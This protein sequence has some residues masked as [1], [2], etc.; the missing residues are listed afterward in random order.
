MRFIVLALPSKPRDVHGRRTHA[1][2]V[3]FGNN[4]IGARAYCSLMHKQTHGRYHVVDQHL[5]ATTWRV[6]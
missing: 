3:P 5:K 2:R 4:E 6:E 1:R